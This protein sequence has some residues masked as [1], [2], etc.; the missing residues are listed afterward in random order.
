M[1]TAGRL[2]ISATTVRVALVAFVLAWILGPDELRRAVPIWI[3][4]LLTN[5][6]ATTLAPPAQQ[7]SVPT[8][9]VPPAGTVTEPDPV[10]SPPDPNHVERA[11]TNDDDPTSTV[12]DDTSS[13]S[14]SLNELP[15]TVP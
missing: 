15:A 8:V 6:G 11:N 7:A 3:V 4:P 12:P 1:D 13:R 10:I 2:S 5:G 9:N 14:S